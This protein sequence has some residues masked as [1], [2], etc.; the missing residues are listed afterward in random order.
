MCIGMVPANVPNQSRF[1]MVFLAPRRI[2]IAG[3]SMRS[4]VALHRILMVLSRPLHPRWPPR[5]YCWFV[6]SLHCYLLMMFA[7]LG[8]DA[9][10]TSAQTLLDTADPASRAALLDSVAHGRTRWQA[11][12]PQ[13]YR[14]RVDLR[15][16]CARLLDNA[17]WVLVR[18]DSILPDSI[19][20]D[21]RFMVVS[22]P[23][24]YTID[25]LF[26][27]LETALR[28]TLVSVTGVRFDPALGFPVSFD[29]RRRCVASRCIYGGTG[30]QVLGFAVVR[31]GPASIPFPDGPDLV[32]AV[33][34]SK[35]LAHDRHLTR[36]EADN[37][38]I[39]RSP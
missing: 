15:C 7:G 6:R 37:G 21:Q 3:H 16:E 39:V 24:Y 31:E 36:A 5:G 13:V 14:V 1:A 17:P 22:R 32:R 23:A 35:S 8:L 4:L 20:A 11:G 30:I 34:G 29:T 28:D 12:R 10:A 18:G 26:A 9:A 33:G 38:S 27:A 25:G 19:R 2:V